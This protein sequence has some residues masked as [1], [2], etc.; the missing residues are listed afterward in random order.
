MQRVLLPPRKP[1]RTRCGARS[2]PSRR[3]QTRWPWE[4]CSIFSKIMC[5]LG[6][7]GREGKRD[8]TAWVLEGPGIRSVNCVLCSQMHLLISNKTLKTQKCLELCYILA[9]SFV[10]RLP[11][12]HPKQW[13]RSKWF[14]VRQSCMIPL[15]HNISLVWVLSWCVPVCGTWE[16][17]SLFFV[18]R[19]HGKESSRGKTAEAEWGD[20][21]GTIVRA[22]PV[23][24]YGQGE[25]CIT[26][27]WLTIPGGGWET[28]TC[29]FRGRTKGRKAWAS[30]QKSHH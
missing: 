26:G 12:A 22:V 27:W 16:I 19:S 28:C 13:S 11:C 10:P 15:N 30:Y 4:F 7:S 29:W 6:F 8:F 20:I 3:C 9:C 18:R 25:K 2:Q 21:A 17:C 24:L 1:Q 23:G 14:L 5:L